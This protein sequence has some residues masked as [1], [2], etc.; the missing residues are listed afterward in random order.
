MVGVNAIRKVRIRKDLFIACIPL[1]FALQQLT[2]GLLWVALEQGEI[3]EAQFWLAN[4][5]GIFIGVIWPFYAPFALYQSEADNRIRKVMASLLVAGLGLA[6]YTIIGLINEPI[7]AHIVND[8]IRYEHDVEAQQFVLTMY[9][10][11]TC[12]PFIL[13]S[14]RYLNI[15]G[16][17]L[18]L[19]FIVAFLAYR[20]T[21]ASIWCFFAAVAS[22]LIYF[23]VANSN[24]K[25]EMSRATQN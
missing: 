22:A 1:L 5:Y 19:G 21:F 4:L 25:N 13:A 24:K 11:A 8:S 18:T 17:A 16:M 6:A 15:T 7:T 10:F 3:P 23:Y 2:E 9:L 12:A 20:E 14:D